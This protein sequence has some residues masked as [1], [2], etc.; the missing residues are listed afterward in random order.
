MGNFVY[1][2][3]VGGS[4]G[5]TGVIDAIGESLTVD[6]G[7]LDN[8]VAHVIQNVDNGTVTANLEHSLNGTTGWTAIGAAIT[9]ASF[10]AGAD[11]VVERTF[12]DSNGMSIRT[13]KIRLKVP[14]TYTGTGTYSLRIGGVQR[15]GFR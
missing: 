10:A 8:I 9:E 14:T 2:D 7:D 4:V 12:S 15:D 3:G 11:T 13:G 1:R 6:V 5:A